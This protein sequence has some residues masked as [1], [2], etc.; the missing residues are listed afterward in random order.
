MAIEFFHI[1]RI[2]RPCGKITLHFL[3]NYIFFD[4][5]NKMT[6]T[7][8]LQFYVLTDVLILKDQ[9]DQTG[10]LWRVKGVLLTIMLRQSV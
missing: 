2:Q 1:L 6:L 4:Q 3:H 10:H 7:E 9:G 5:V 8:L